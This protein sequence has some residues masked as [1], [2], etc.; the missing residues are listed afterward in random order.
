MNRLLV[1]TSLLVLLSGVSFWRESASGCAIAPH[2]NK[3]VSI[4][5]ESAIIVWD[6]ASK[7]EH[8][9]RRAS[10][11]T[12]SSDFGFLVPTPTK[13]ELSETED[14]VFTHLAK[15]TA[16]RVVTMNRPSSGG[17]CACGGW[18]ASPMSKGAAKPAVEVLDEKKNLAG[19]DVVVLAAK[20]GQA[21]TDWLAKNDYENSPAL[22]DWVKPYLDEGYVITAFKFSQE[23]LSSASVGTKAVHMTFHADRPFYPYK[24]PTPDAPKSDDPLTGRLLRV[25]FL[26]DSRYQGKLGEK[27]AWPGRTAWAGALGDADRDAVWNMLKLPAGKVPQPWWLTE[28]ED[29]SSPRP[30][31]ADVFFSPSEDQKPVEREPHIHYVSQPLPDCIMCYAI[32]ACLVTPSLVRRWRRGSRQDRR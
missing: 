19:Y 14:D 3:P 23:A 4:A 20:D 9:I 10:F 12:A 22:K 13:P 16:P 15:I 5:S 27:G 26:S 28:F 8:F 1:C 32:A 25:F 17:G 31:T 11:N 30:A 21:L 24:E 18:P 29:S 2:R 7:T 6:S